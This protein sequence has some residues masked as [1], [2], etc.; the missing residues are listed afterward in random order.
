M[1][2]P[3]QPAKRARRGRAASHFTQRI[4]DATPRNVTGDLREESN[5]MTSDGFG[6]VLLEK[7]SGSRNQLQL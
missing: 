4:Y 2:E 6:C 1:C 3:P 5:E 7:V